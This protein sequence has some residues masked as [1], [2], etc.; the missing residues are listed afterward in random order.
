MQAF[1]IGASGCLG[2]ELIPA[3][4][5]L[6][7]YRAGRVAGEVQRR[8]LHGRVY[9]PATQASACSQRGRQVKVKATTSAAAVRVMIHTSTAMEA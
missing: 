4:D 9:R 6:R 5:C 1:I 8:V 3:L 2:R 7:R